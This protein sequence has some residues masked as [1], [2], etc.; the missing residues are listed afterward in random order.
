MDELLKYDYK[1]LKKGRGLGT[2]LLSGCDM[3]MKRQKMEATREANCRAH[4]QE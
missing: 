2:I 3:R 1:S 4:A